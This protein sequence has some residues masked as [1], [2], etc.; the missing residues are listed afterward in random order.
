MQEKTPGL[1]VL[2]K[3]VLV[4]FVGACVYGAWLFLR[5]QLGRMLS[6]AAGGPAA[7]SP[8]PGGGT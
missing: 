3:L 1:T 4:V 6:P 5:P 8:S 2:G 7:A